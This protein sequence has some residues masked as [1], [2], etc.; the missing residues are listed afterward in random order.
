[1]DD[2]PVGRGTQLQVWIRGL[3]V[4]ATM[5]VLGAASTTAL[6]RVPA[7][8]PLWIGLTGEVLALAGVAF[9]GGVVHALLMGYRPANPADYRRL[10]HSTGADTPPVTVL[11][12]ARCRPLSRMR[13]AHRPWLLGTRAVYFFPDEPTAGQ[14]GINVPRAKRGRYFYAD[15]ATITAPMYVR[16]DG[17]IAVCGPVDVTPTWPTAVPPTQ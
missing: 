5:V 1:M 10:W 7:H 15:P 9:V 2:E 14:L 3:C 6:T 8:V 4:I 13:F 17:A 11:D 12:P 16:F